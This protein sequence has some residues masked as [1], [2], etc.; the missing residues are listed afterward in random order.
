MA[1]SALLLT[2]LGVDVPFHHTQLEGTEEERPFLRPASVEQEA[3]RGGVR[4][5]EQEMPRVTVALVC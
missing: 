2:A 3:D 1:R 4:Q 5:G